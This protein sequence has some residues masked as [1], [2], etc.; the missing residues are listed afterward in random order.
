MQF[1]KLD[2]PLLLAPMSGVTN[3]AFRALCRKLGASLCYTEF[4]SAD[5]LI[6]Y[7]DQLAD[8][9]YDVV[10]NERPVVTQIFGEDEQKL[11]EAAQ[12]V[13]GTCDVIDLN[14]GC[15]APKVMACGGGSALLNDPAKVRRILTR[16][17][18]LPVPITCK[19]RLGVNWDNITAFEI[20]KIAE[21]TGCVAIAVHARTASMGYS[22]N[23]DWSY[24]K[25]I[26]ELVNIPVIGNGDITCAADVKR[27]ID[28]TGC[29]YVMIGRAAM[30]DPFIF[31]RA[32]HYLKT[33][34]NVDPVSWPEKLALFR[35]YLVLL[36]TYGLDHVGHIRHMF[37]QFTKGYAGGK[38]LRGKSLEY[39]TKE[40]LLDFI[41]KL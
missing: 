34:K 29:D 37:M 26:K 23:A 17:N 27:M 33:G 13:V 20:A 31:S 8:H 5:A 36:E 39:K 4:I 16:L 3:V 1:L 41:K 9:I 15:P 32:K 28:E 25:K 10:P 2:S 11:F 6:R 14:I 38:V 22:G 40:D 12:A 30:R 19:I 35:E 18:T 7:K 24:I 21:D